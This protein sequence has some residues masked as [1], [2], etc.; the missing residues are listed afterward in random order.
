LQPRRQL[1]PPPVELGT[2]TLDFDITAKKALRPKPGFASY[3]KLPEYLTSS[4][5][6]PKHLLLSKDSQA[7]LAETLRE[8]LVLTRY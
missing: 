6:G 1:L 7:A 4:L 2:A 3:S 8:R 5:P